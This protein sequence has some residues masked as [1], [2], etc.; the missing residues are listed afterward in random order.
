[1]VNYPRKSVEP[2]VPAFVAIC[3]FPLIVWAQ[4]L[5]EKSPVDTAVLV[6]SVLK[7]D[8]AADTINVSPF[9][10]PA[11]LRDVRYY[12][13]TD[14]SQDTTSM[15]VPC[16]ISVV[17]SKIKKDPALPIYTVITCHGANFETVEHT[18]C[19]NI[20]QPP[21]SVMFQEN[22]RKVGLPFFISGG[23]AFMIGI[24]QILAFIDYSTS[25]SGDNTQAI[26]SSAQI[27]IGGLAVGGV[28]IFEGFKKLRIHQRWEN[29]YQFKTSR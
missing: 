12:A 25:N 28:L 14:E 3:F 11:K 24:S 4:N 21:E 1:V 7:P 16:S 29:R 27:A 13:I 23:I 6:Q 10:V 9:F 26:R 8:F 19:G 2:S 15:G 20:C 18:G 17:R 22:P 5:P